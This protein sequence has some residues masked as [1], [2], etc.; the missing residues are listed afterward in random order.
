MLF[1]DLP[2]APS[3]TTHSPPQPQ[4]AEMLKVEAKLARKK[5][6]DMVIGGLW[7][8]TVGVFLVL[9]VVLDVDYAWI[10]FPIAGMLNVILANAYGMNGD[11][12][13]ALNDLEREQGQQRAERMRI[14][15]EQYHELD[16][17]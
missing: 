1:D 14:I 16:E 11:E 12:I 7:G 15:A 2:A 4:Q 6:I 10:V 13:W 17:Q 9:G 8:V 3:Q 5:R